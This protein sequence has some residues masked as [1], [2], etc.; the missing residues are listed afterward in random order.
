[1]SVG[2]GSDVLGNVFGVALGKNLDLFADVLDLFLGLL[3]T[4][5]SSAMKKPAAT[6]AQRAEPL[7]GRSL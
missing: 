4:S 7:R 1:M 5:N 3:S 2:V 6:S